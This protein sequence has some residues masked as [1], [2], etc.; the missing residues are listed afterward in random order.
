[1]G[2]IALIQRYVPHYQETILKKMYE[3]LPHNLTFVYGK[4][5]GSGASGLD[6]TFELGVKVHNTN[7]ELFG[8]DIVIQSG[9]VTEIL[10]NTY[11]V[12]ICEG[13]PFILSNYPIIILSKM[14]GTKIALWTKGISTFPGN[15]W[16]LKIREL[17][18]GMFLRLVDA[19]IVYGSISKNY[20]LAKGIQEEKIFLAQNTLDTEEIRDNLTHYEEQGKKIREEL[21][22]TSKKVILSIGRLNKEKGV[23]DLIMAF[24]EVLRVRNDAVLVIVGEGPYKHALTSLAVDLVNRSVFFVGQVP[25]D[26]EY[27][28]FA[29]SDVVVLPGHVGLAAIQ[30]MSLG[31]A[32]ICADEQAPEAEFIIDG[33]SGFRVKKNDISGIS[34][35]IVKLLSDPILTKNVGM[36][37]QKLVFE[38]A[39][40]QNM[41]DG[42]GKAINYLIA[43]SRERRKSKY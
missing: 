37:A 40:L 10:K 16:Q 18:N 5:I 42:V 32:V 17:V 38:K 34:E 21:S 6:S 41:I 23:G 28:F 33:I 36:T 14:K 19:Y 2:K 1:M 3:R 8:V 24:K 29:M 7:L 15:H 35:T 25:P 30:A 4:K 31:K 20:L 39:P 12:V 27:K 9:A 13:S 43:E 26:E 22:L 11:D